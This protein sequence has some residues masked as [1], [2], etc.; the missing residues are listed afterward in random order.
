VL[1]PALVVW[2]AHG[3][4]G[5]SATADLDALDKMDGAGVELVEV[6]PSSAHAETRPTTAGAVAFFP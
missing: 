4:E 1:G 2:H 5:Q 3:L 6:P